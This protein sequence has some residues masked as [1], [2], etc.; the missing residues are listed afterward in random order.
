MLDVIS[1]VQ[2]L[3]NGKI[4]PV[5]VKAVPGLVV[6]SCRMHDEHRNAVNLHR[7]RLFFNRREPPSFLC[8][9]VNGLAKLPSVR[10]FNLAPEATR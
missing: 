5:L 4:D 6:V 10:S 1:G 3:E 7:L 8:R 2:V 9:D